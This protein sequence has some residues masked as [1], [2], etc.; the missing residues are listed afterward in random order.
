MKLFKKNP[1]YEKELWSANRSA[2][3]ALAVMGYHALLAVIALAVFSNMLNVIRVR[4]QGNYS[5]MLQMYIVLAMVE[6]MLVICIMPGMAGGGISKERERHALELMQV[7]G[8]SSVRIVLGKLKSYMNTVIVLILSGFPALS[9]VYVYGGIQI[10]DFLWVAA[11]LLVTACY[12]CS[13]S[14]FCSAAAK[15]TGHAIVIAYGTVLSLLGGTLLIHYYQFLLLGGTYGEQIGSPIA[16]YHYL[17][18]LNPLVTFYGMMNKQAGSRDFIFDMI[19]YQ[20]NYRP[21]WVTENWIGLSLALQLAV[22][23]LFLAGTVHEIGKK[24]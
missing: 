17:L 7:S 24:K 1:V 3:F 16:W 20:G 8:I 10:G 23:V 15:K 2:F 9:L 5:L 21:N 13:I 4:G 22:S 18:L 19:N 6:C 14:L 11:A 12:L